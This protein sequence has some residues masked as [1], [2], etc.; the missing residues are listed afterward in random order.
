[1]IRWKAIYCN[2]QNGQKSVLWT[3]I[4]AE[5]G[6]W[7]K[8]ETQREADLITDWHFAGIHSILVESSFPSG[9]MEPPRTVS[10]FSLF[11]L[12]RLWN[13]WQIC[14]VRKALWTLVMQLRT[15][16]NRQCNQSFQLAAWCITQVLSLTEF[17]LQVN[18][19]KPDV[20]LS[21]L[22]ASEVSFHAVSLDP[23]WFWIPCQNA[24]FSLGYKAGW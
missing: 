17:R 6:I 14:I 19:V 2:Q 8:R 24:T 18:D 7:A 4:L 20:D 10:S 12:H 3:N 23:L 5:S 22:V 16:F 11:C 21:E 1:M 15:H 13:I 9:M